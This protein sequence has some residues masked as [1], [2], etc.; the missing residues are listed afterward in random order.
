MMT[1]LLTCTLIMFSIFSCFRKKTPPNNIEAWLGQE[2]PGKYEVLIS[3]LKMLDVMAQF[4]GEKRALIAEKSDPEVQVLLDWQKDT[5]SL[6]LDPK[7]V[8]RLFDYARECKGKS[9]EL[10]NLLKTKGLEK[11]AVGY[12]DHRIIIQVFEEPT[13][14]IREQ[15]LSVV[16]Q[17]LDAWLKFPGHTLYVQLM[18][19]AAYGSKFQHFIPNGHFKIENPWQEENCILSFQNEWRQDLNLSELTW[20]IN[21]VSKRGV[22]YKEIAF[23]QAKAWAEKNLPKPCFMD[24]GQTVGFEVSKTGEEKGLQLP[25]KGRPAI[26]YAFPYFNKKPVDGSAEPKGY[27]KGVFTLDDQ[28]FSLIRKDKELW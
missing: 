15:T 28:A 18:E 27:V 5:A 4:K 16:K 8:T 6:G 22:Q 24:A 2:F 1:K 13:P 9:L 3:N 17:A 12:Y 25:P 23:E 26:R 20:D 11:C 19:P 14:E 10:Y 21:P 7:E